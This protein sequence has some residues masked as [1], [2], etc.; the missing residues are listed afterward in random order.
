MNQRTA[1]HA[2]K[3]ILV[4]EDD[5]AIAEMLILL[6]TSVGYRVT[7]VAR[8]EEAHS[9]LSTPAGSPNPQVVPSSVRLG[10]ETSYPDLVLLDLRLPGLDGAEMM[11]QLARSVQHLPPVIV[12]SAKPRGAVDAAA[13]S[14]GAV[15]AVA[16]PFLIEELLH[17]ID[18]ALATKPT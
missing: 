8:P 1:Q 7:C 13:Q 11:R 4:V 15:D 12:L 18:E 3:H 16:K 5:E 10:G 6:L 9:I 17:R 2:G 14:I